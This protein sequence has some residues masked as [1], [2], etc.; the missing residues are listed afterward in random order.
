M[1]DS[2]IFSHAQVTPEPTIVHEVTQDPTV[3]I[4]TYRFNGNPF[5]KLKDY[6][7]KDVEVR[8]SDGSTKIGPLDISA[9]QMSIQWA[10]QKIALV[11]DHL[12]EKTK[13][14][15]PKIISIARKPHE[16]ELHP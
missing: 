14:I 2:L 8:F 6:H 12:W 11:L 3:L 15:N 9:H 13:H 7:G 4:Q 10:G 16:N 1:T 5:E